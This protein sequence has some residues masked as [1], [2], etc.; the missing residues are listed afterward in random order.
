MKT[1]SLQQ[2]ARNFNVSPAEKKKYILSTDY[3]FEILAGC[4]QLEN[5][6]LAEEDRSLVKLIK[7][8]LEADWRKPLLSALDKLLRKY[9]KRF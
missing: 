3:D 9:K 7:T 2:L 5:M 1:K 4:R 8:Q 6:K